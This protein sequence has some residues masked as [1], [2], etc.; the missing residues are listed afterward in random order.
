M[1]DVVLLFKRLSLVL[2]VNMV[3]FSS[4]GAHHGFGTYSEETIVVDGV[5]KDFFF[6]NPHPQVSLEVDGEI[7]NVWLA[8]YPR[9]VYAC[10]DANVLSVG[11]E[12][13]AIGHKI[14][15]R[16]EMKTVKVEHHG[17]LFDFYP[18]DNP[19]VGP[20]ANAR[21]VREGPCDY[22]LEN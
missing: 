13:R 3:T 8:A 9:V 6:G 20:N 7:W 15:N 17:K 2:L 10:F 19:D 4:V 22:E 5:V 18:P 16:L 11:D 14:A 1:R 21:R 12:L